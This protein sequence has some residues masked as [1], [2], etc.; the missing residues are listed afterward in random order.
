MSSKLPFSREARTHLSEHRDYFRWFNP[1]ETG[2]PLR[3]KL[4]DPEAGTFR[5]H[6]AAGDVRI[7]FVYPLDDNEDS[8]DGRL[9]LKDTFIFDPFERHLKDFR[10][11]I[12]GKATPEVLSGAAR[13][14]ENRPRSIEDL[15]VRNFAAD[16][17]ALHGRPLTG[18]ILLALKSQIAHLQEGLAPLFGFREGM[19][20]K[21]ADPQTHFLLQRGEEAY[22]FQFNFVVD[23]DAD[24]ANGRLFW[25]ERFS[26]DARTGQLRDFARDWEVAADS[27]AEF[28]EAFAAWRDAKPR[29]ERNAERMNAFAQAVAPAMLRAARVNTQ[30]R[31]FERLS[32]RREAQNGSL[33]QANLQGLEILQSYWLEK[34]SRFPSEFQGSDLRAVVDLFRKAADEARTD[35]AGGPFAALER[36]ATTP[37]EQNWAERLAADDLSQKINLLSQDGGDV[38]ST[39]L[40]TLIREDLLKR[41]YFTAAS[42]AL[43]KL[44][45]GEMKVPAELEGKIAGLE[46]WLAGEGS[47]GMKAEAWLPKAARQAAAPAALAAF[48]AAPLGGAWV[49]AGLVA[50][51][52]GRG[53]GRILA[54]GAGIAGEAATLTAVQNLALELNPNA[55]ARWDRFGSDFIAASY[56]FGF[57][58]LGNGLVSQASGTLA[59][60]TPGSWLAKNDVAFVY[61]V[62]PTG[63]LYT[64]ALR[65]GLNRAGEIMVGGM[66]HATGI[67]AILAS[68][69]LSNLHRNPGDR[70]GVGLLDSA[71]EYA[72]VLVGY[73][74]FN[75]L[76][77]GRLSSTLGEARLR[78]QER[79]ASA[80]RNAPLDTPVTGGTGTIP[81]IFATA[82][83]PKV[84]WPRTIRPYKSNLIELYGKDLGREMGQTLAKLYGK[85][86]GMEPLFNPLRLGSLED[87]AH[88]TA[89]AE[90]RAFL[91][92]EGAARNPLEEP[93]WSWLRE[94]ESARRPF[95]RAVPEDSTPINSRYRAQLRQ[96]FGN[97]AGEGAL[98]FAALAKN[99]PATA[100]EFNPEKLLEIPPEQFLEKFK[101]AAGPK[102]GRTTEEDAWAGAK[103]VVET[104]QDLVERKSPL[105]IAEGWG[106]KDYRNRDE[107]AWRLQ[108]GW[109]HLAG[110]VPEAA[111]QLNNNWASQKHFQIVGT[112]GFWFI[113]DLGSKHGTKLD[114]RPLLP[115]RPE[116]LKAGASIS[117]G[118]YNYAFRLAPKGDAFL[119]ED[120]P[121]PGTSP[122][123]IEDEMTLIDIRPSFSEN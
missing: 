35:P 58:R 117:A 109:V 97:E 67:G 39:A 122:V 96:L 72:Q 75:G 87:N 44:R 59:R 74:L 6:T 69:A 94:I 48:L 1:S 83:L 107:R 114:G 23:D 80:A 49:E 112:N 50:R 76:T 119:V 41:D 27:P 106:L 17:A 11:E 120:L 65:P 64:A 90:A 4:G 92:R 14:W 103:S 3:I 121:K 115:H 63:R 7:A 62:A 22:K 61:P 34:A 56:L 77:Y 78:L 68:H 19:R 52:G 110:R 93:V 16:V 118:M 12:S 85:F 73:H 42:F 26:V 95:L 51:L 99:F 66:Y 46:A 57:L 88:Y 37:V 55:P 102:V 100:S 53:A 25:V 21:I 79:R 31:P 116:P 36:A 13:L 71:L 86:P 28:K 108:D 47:L 18:E 30:P 43:G 89:F 33:R 38:R 45:E 54:Q 105:V 24:P 60:G 98:G 10:S 70:T 15:R 84:K 8:S 32:E 111:I 123:V 81:R 9:Y 5:D 101:A 113:Q 91:L 2:S 82:D 40:F 29:D 20:L 104:L